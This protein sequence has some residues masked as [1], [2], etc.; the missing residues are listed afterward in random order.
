MN[1][2]RSK[3]GKNSIAYNKLIIG[4]SQAPCFIFS[5]GYMS[6]MSGTKALYIEEYCKKK[7]YN[8]IR[9]DN[10]GCGNSSGDFINQTIS[11]WTKGLIMVVDAL[12]NGPVFLIGSSLGAW[13]SFLTALELPKKI[14]GIISISAG[15]DFTEELIW[16]NLKPEDKETLQNEEIYYACGTHA[17]CTTKYPIKMSL[18][19][20]GRKN[21]VL[22]GSK[23]DISCPVHLIHGMQDKDV[24]YTISTRASEKLVSSNVV[25]KLIKDGAHN[26]SRPSDLEIICH[27]IDEIV[28]SAA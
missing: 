3:D 21:L 14:L 28:K 11:D 17:E 20:D 1:I 22:S 15:F 26:L 6:D 23:I 18:I 27:S 12:S 2:L 13:I 25:L 4:K 24:P 8:Y 10:F 5:H 9:F 7:S 16:Q 19:K